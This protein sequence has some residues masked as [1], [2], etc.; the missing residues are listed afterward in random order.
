MA[1]LWLQ[2]HV[3]F[4]LWCEGSIILL[5]LSMSLFSFVLQILQSQFWFVQFTV[6]CCIFYFC[7]MLINSLF[8]VQ[9]SSHYFFAFHELE[10]LSIT[11]ITIWCHLLQSNTSHIIQYFLEF[12][13]FRVYL[14]WLH[15]ESY[16]SFKKIKIF[17]I[18]KNVWHL[19]RKSNI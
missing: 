7:Y 18:I 6:S 10:G 11:I 8:F 9:N 4:F 13:A 1:F 2:V 14:I 3:T 16:V 19:L 12:I 17:Q 5:E 15:C